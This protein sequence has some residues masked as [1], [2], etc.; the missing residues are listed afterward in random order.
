MSEAIK[1]ILDYW[2]TIEL[3]K[4]DSFD[5]KTGEREIKKGDIIEVT[6]SFSTK[7]NIV[8]RLEFEKNKHKWKFCSA[9]TIYMGLIERNKCLEKVVELID[10]SVEFPEK[11]QQCDRIACASLQ[12][13]HDGRYIENSFDL[14]PLLWT[15]DVLQ[16]EENFNYK[17]YRDVIY[18]WEKNI[19]KKTFVRKKIETDDEGNTNEISVF[20]PETLD[21]LW[22]EL[23]DR[24]S[25]D[26]LGII[27]EEAGYFSFWIY[28]DDKEKKEPNY[29]GLSMKFFADDI[30]MVANEFEHNN[31]YLQSMAATQLSKYIQSPLLKLDESVRHS[32][33][34]NKTDD[35]SHAELFHKLADILS[36]KNAPLGKWPSA[37]MPAFMQQVAV[38][39]FVSENSDLMHGQT[40]F[41]VNGPPGTGK[42]TMLK[43]IVAHNVVERARLL[44]RYNTSDEAF[45][46]C[47]FLYGGIEG[48]G[49]KKKYYRYVEPG[50]YKLKED[51]INDYGIMVT[52]CNNSAV[53]NISK[54]LPKASDIIS[55]LKKD[56]AQ[57]CIGDLFDV[58]KSNVYEE[59]R[60]RESGQLTSQQ[61]I[62]FS[63][64]ATELLNS[65]EQ[66]WGLVA[67]AL[68]KKDNIRKFAYNVLNPLI[69]N[70]KAN[71]KIESRKASYSRVKQDFIKQIDKVKKL[72][73][74]LDEV[75]QVVSRLHK[76][77][78]IYEEYQQKYDKILIQVS[79]W[80]RNASLDIKNLLSENKKKTQIIEL[81]D[82]YQYE[83]FFSKRKCN[84]EHNSRIDNRIA[85]IM[86]E[87]YSIDFP[88]MADDSL[89]KWLINIAVW[90]QNVCNKMKEWGNRYRK[91]PILF[92]TI[93]NKDFNHYIDEYMEHLDKCLDELD[94]QEKTINRLQRE[95]C[96]AQKEL[97]NTQ[98]NYTNQQRLVSRFKNSGILFFD[99]A[100]MDNLLSDDEVV[101][102]KAQ[103]S[104]PWFTD[105]YNR[106][107]E[108]LFWLA[109]QVHKEFILS[110]KKW[111]DNIINLM[112]IWDVLKKKD[113]ERIVYH[114]TDRKAAMPALLQSLSLLVPVIS[115]TFAAVGRFLRDVQVPGAIGTLIVDEAG[116]AEPQMAL[117]ALYRSRRAIIVGDPKQVEP[118]VTNELDLLK[119][120][121]TEDIYRGYTDKG[122]SVQQFADSINKWGTYLKPDDGGDNREW[123]GCPLL[124]HRRC[125]N[126]MYN[127]SNQISYG[128][129]MKKQT[130]EPGDEKKKNFLYLKS[131][132]FDV[133][134][135]EIG[136]KDHFVELQGH[137]VV[138]MMKRAFQNKPDNP[139]IYI[140]S[141]FTSVV[142]R[143]T[144]LLKKEL[145]TVNNIQEWCRYNIG[146]VHKFQGKE[147]DE[148]I[149][150]LGC[151][152]SQSARG[153]VNWVNSNIVNVAVTRAK[154]RLYVIGA[155]DVWK[156]SYWVNKM[157]T[158]MDEENMV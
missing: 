36:I 71:E 139:N 10:N 100:Y 25:L 31:D 40:I 91:R 38:N 52:S 90:K 157:M 155:R 51:K 43:E 88:S 126:P 20:Y 37:H 148:V 75:C 149:F 144:W 22:Q 125:I 138:E 127:I 30:D 41:S 132:W 117:G 63:K 34:F 62:Y 158:I 101:N 7:E 130:A 110:S 135:K 35:K 46:N 107:R 99:A 115:T 134:G 140:I 118:V 76:L 87:D 9:I 48:K 136:N 45:E 2:Y 141:P 60:D 142:N 119:S 81:R 120:T 96:E 27:K 33:K 131:C 66:A 86:K 106:E 56:D 123:L 24:Y 122:I 156:H 109:M 13:T 105:E 111:R 14:S 93:E 108:K 5:K 83:G 133:T 12:L 121:Y 150:V 50:Y 64:F 97:D 77:S 82:T 104:N 8:E 54:E 129:M 15:I 154:Y 4:Q 80:K 39:I 67:A 102:T 94:K 57:R 73:V 29:H 145:S 18:S 23:Y 70:F 28:K 26:D 143:V 16:T 19:C 53:E 137:R 85:L 74:Q 58:S 95:M 42:T 124:V 146:T 128:G 55:S 116:Q 11:Y 65:S 72:R 17:Q 114:E 47:D 92:W 153:A 44:V 61:D 103:V 3:L 84:C 98:K 89:E 32:I 1:K 152:D 147:A 6:E 69:D 112:L 49:G 78:I 113:D 79:E 151:D 59:I 68:G 21:D